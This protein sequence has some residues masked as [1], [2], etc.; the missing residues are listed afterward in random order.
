MENEQRLSLLHGVPSGISQQPLSACPPWPRAPFT[1]LK[2]DGGGAEETG[3]RRGLIVMV[4]GGTTGIEEDAGD[5]STSYLRRSGSEETGNIGD[6]P[7]GGA[8][9]W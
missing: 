4:G 6:G 1:M 8:W 5:A 3:R 7:D 2:G 9:W